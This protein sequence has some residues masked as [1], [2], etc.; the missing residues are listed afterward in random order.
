MPAPPFKVETGGLGIWYHLEEFKGADCQVP[1]GLRS[2]FSLRFSCSFLRF[3]CVF[4][5]F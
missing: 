1:M 5:L 3:S 2:A 4:P